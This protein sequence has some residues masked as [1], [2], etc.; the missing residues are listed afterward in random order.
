MIALL[1]V[2]LAGQPAVANGPLVTRDASAGLAPAVSAVATAVDDTA[3]I[4]YAV[5]ARGGDR[6]CWDQERAGVS[7]PSGV[8]RLEPADALHVLLRVERGQVVRVRLSSPDCAIDAGG[9]T[10]TWLT[11]VRAA[12]SVALLDGYASRADAPRALADGALAAL[13]LHA[14]PAALDRLLALARDATTGHTR[15]QALFWLGQ[16]AGDRAAGAITR[17]IETDP[18]TAVKR[19]AVFAL[20]QLPA[21]DGVPR[22]IEVARAHSNAS[23]RK[24][25]FFWL[26]QSKDPR[27]LAFFEEVLRR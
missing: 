8:T 18:D 4:G 27:A 11:G 6:V 22:L 26:G 17:A 23:V 7:N 24:Q 14:E 21:A 5:P 1:L 3:W 12:D 9:R 20:S 15:G 13:A 16:R 10:L 25:A 19:Q 2:A